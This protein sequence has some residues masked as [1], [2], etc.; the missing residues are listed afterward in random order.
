MPRAPDVAWPFDARGNV[1]AME[2]SAV[3]AFIRADE[4]AQ[5]PVRRV[6]LPRATAV[7]D[8]SVDEAT[9]APVP[10]VVTPTPFPGQ[11]IPAWTPVSEED[12]TKLVHTMGIELTMMSPMM[13][14]TGYADIMNPFARI[15]DHVLDKEALG[16]HSRSAHKDSYA[17]E[18]PSKPISTLG[19]VKKFYDSVSPI[20]R[21]LGLTPH[22]PKLTSG[23]GHIH[24]GGMKDRDMINIV[25]HVQNNPWLAW[26]FNEPDDS[27]SAVSYTEELDDLD[28]TLRDAAKT[29]NTNPTLFCDELSDDAQIAFLFYGNPEFATRDY[30]PDDKS[31]VVRYCERHK[32]L[33]FR[34]F[35]APVDWDEQEAHVRFLDAYIR[36]IKSKYA[37]EFVVV[38]VDT[39]AKLKA[40]TKAQCE[41]AFRAFLT[42]LGLPSAPYERMIT[43]NLG[44]RFKKGK[45]V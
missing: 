26:T 22:H 18:V 14:T 31:H 33:E 21:G 25:R 1:Q 37:K 28:A 40:F 7:P 41:Q 24:V 10:V 27:N 19:G 39:A 29:C 4:P 35:E 38:E 2:G 16:L 12:K 13:K 45:R 20:M 23:G 5:T 42:E 15:I 32:T 30:I 44:Y 9:E 17:V 6:R 11:P 8:T 3:A 43:E 34:F 36:H